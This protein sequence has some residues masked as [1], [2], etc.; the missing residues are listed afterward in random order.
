V[1]DHPGDELGHRIGRNVIWVDASLNAAQQQLAYVAV[2]VQAFG[3][4]PALPPQADGP[5]R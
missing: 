1:G 5:S 4:P 2:R 3:L